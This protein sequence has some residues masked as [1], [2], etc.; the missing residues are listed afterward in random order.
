MECE[1]WIPN[2]KLDFEIPRTKIDTVIQF[3][4]PSP[5]VPT[6]TRRY[7]ML[8]ENK[9]MEPAVQSKRNQIENFR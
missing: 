6:P 1:I 2:L 9:I 7:Q 4:I 8:M 5:T 3:F